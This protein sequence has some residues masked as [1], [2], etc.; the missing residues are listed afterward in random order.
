MDKSVH[1]CL[2]AEVFVIAAGSLTNELELRQR[3]IA[4]RIRISK[5]VI[6]S[7]I[8]LESDKGSYGTLL[9]S[10]CQKGELNKDKELLRLMRGKG[11]APQYG[12]SNV[13]LVSLSEAGMTDEAIIAL[14][15]SV[16]MRFKPLSNSLAP[17]R[18]I[19]L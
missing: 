6:W 1:I 10:L 13:L 14:R 9:K 8:D 5:T 15:W 2:R 18:L 3:L 17:F 12:T 16:E 19:N 11:F 7:R 4:S